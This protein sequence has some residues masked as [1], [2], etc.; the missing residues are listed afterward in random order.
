MNPAATKHLGLEFDSEE[1]LHSLICIVAGIEERNEL[2]RFVAPIHVEGEYAMTH[3]ADVS[4]Q[5]LQLS[6]FIILVRA[7]AFNECLD[8]V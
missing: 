7:V 4:H 8:A 2:F 6:P 3:S 5:A 1:S